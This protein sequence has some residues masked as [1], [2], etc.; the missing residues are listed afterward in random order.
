MHNA[1]Q[2]SIGKPAI[3]WDPSPN[4]APR[5]Q[6]KIQFLVLHNTEGPFAES[7]AA[8]K[9]PASRVSAHYLIDRNGYIYQLVPDTQTS[10]HSR[11]KRMNQQSIGIELVASE[12]M[13]NLAPV[14]ES[15]LVCLA[16][17]LMDT[18]DLPVSNVILHRAVSATDCP[19]WLWEDD[20]SYES[21]KAARLLSK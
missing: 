2:E 17:F 9:D 10:W 12:A 20:A 19:R 13:R 14:Q 16:R 4:R 7:L 15:A 3:I 11:N 18:Y 8:L 21:W 5:G 1:A 6:E